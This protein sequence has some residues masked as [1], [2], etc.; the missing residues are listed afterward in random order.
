MTQT[1]HYTFITPEA[2]LALKEWMDFRAAHG[3]Q[4]TGESWL[5]R[6]TWCTT[7]IKTHGGK[8]GLAT[9]PKKIDS[10]A[11]K[12][13]IA[14]A[15]KKQGIRYA[16]TDN[17]CRYEFKASHGLRKFFKTRAQQ[18]MSHLNTELLMGH[19]LGL[20]DSYYKPQEADVLSDY[21]KAVPLLTII[22]GADTERLEKELKESKARQIDPVELAELRA[23]QNRYNKLMA[24]D[25]EKS[26]GRLGI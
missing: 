1:Q 24:Y 23:N 13:I 22:S 18:V 16:L 6:D 14:R 8:Y 21:L 20:T 7:D 5:M 9:C 3:E 2:Y 26:L 17:A 15:L 12:K 4:I 19:S 25:H 10:D 11:V